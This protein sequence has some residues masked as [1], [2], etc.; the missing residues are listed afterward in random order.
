MEEQL[1]DSFPGV[2]SLRMD[3]DTTQTRNAH[4]DILSR[5]SKGEAQ[6]L[7]GTQMVAKGLDM[8]NVSLVGIVAA[9][10]SL[11]IP[12][13]RSCGRFSFLLRWPDGQAGQTATAE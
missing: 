9:D 10:A 3:M 2:K 4:Y 7:I 6:V 13:Y 5:F 11:H 12:D 1:R 8:P